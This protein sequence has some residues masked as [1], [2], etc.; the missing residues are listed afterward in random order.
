MDNRTIRLSDAIEALGKKRYFGEPYTDHEVSYNTAIEDSI[1]AL[2]ALPAVDGWL[3]IENAPDD[4]TP[5]WG[6]TPTGAGHPHYMHPYLMRHEGK[7]YSTFQYNNGASW[8]DW[9]KPDPTHYMPLP[10]PPIA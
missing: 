7:L 4:G 9:P 2:S 3:P 1:A 10:A 6:I 8:V 5:F